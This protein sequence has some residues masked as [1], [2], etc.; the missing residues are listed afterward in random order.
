MEINL[1]W[2]RMANRCG[3]CRIGTARPI[4]QEAY[5]CDYCGLSRTE[6]EEYEMREFRN[7]VDKTRMRQ[8]AFEKEIK[9]Y[10]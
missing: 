2:M 7:Q 8:I 5:M 3:V 1:D 9:F 10:G 4:G 6:R